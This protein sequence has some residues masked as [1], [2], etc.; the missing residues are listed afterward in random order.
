M[1]AFGRNRRPSPMFAL[2]GR[3]GAAARS[4]RWVLG[5]VMIAALAA[6]NESSVND[7][8]SSTSGTAIAAKPV[9]SLEPNPSSIVKGSLTALSWSASG[10]Q[11]CAASGG[12]SGTRPTTGTLSIDRLNATTTYTLTCTGPGGSTTQTTKVAVT[13]SPPSVTLTAGPTTLAG[14]GSATLSWNSTDATVCTASRGWSGPVATSGSWSTGALSNTTDY[15]LTCTGVGGSATQSAT[16][17]VSELAS[18]VALTANPSTV[19]SGSATTLTW[20]SSGATTCSA[21]GAWLGVKAAHGSQSTGPLT[22]NAT[23][24]LICTGAMGSATQSATVSVKSPAPTV[25]LGAGPSTLASGTSSTL[26]WSAANATSCEASGAW[27]GLRSVSGVQSTGVLTAGATY[28]LTCAGPGGSAAQ[29]ATVSVKPQAPSVSLSVGPSAIA[30]GGSA[31][32]NWSA[33]NA[34]TCSASGGWS[35]S[36]AITGSQSTGTLK[37][38]AIFTLTCSG[39]GGSA[40]QSATLTVSLHPTVTVGFSASPSTIAS[41]RGSTLTWS[42]NG[43]TSCTA[44]GAWSGSKALSG[45]QSTG[46]LTANATYILTCSGNGGSATQSVT[47]SVTAPA[48]TISLGAS[49]STVASGSGST[50]TWS[51]TNATSCTGSGAWSG[52]KAISGSQSTG[53]LTADESYTLTCSGA[54]GSAAQS[55]TVSVTKPAPTVS[56]AASP[57]TIA[58]GSSSTLTWSTANATACTASGT[59]SGSKAVN[60]SASTGALAADETYTLTC[61]GSGGSAV[62][63]ATVSVTTPAPAVSFS[64]SPSTVAKGAISTLTWSSTHATSCT[65]SGGWSGP[66][67]TSGSQAT[68]AIA[69]T[70]TYTLSCSGPG[71]SATQSATVTTAGG[72]GT[73]TLS[74]VAPTTNTNGTPVTPLSGYHI[75]YGTSASALTQSV[76]IS[77]T[78]TASYEITGLTSGTWYFAVAA[79]A[80][81]GTESALS[82][83]GSK[84]I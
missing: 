47:V 73:A 8:S 49:P 66:E 69:V 60:G 13:S 29:S 78:A 2:H 10:A 18:L 1:F 75:Y 4:V 51:S 56:L 80:S 20:S 35:G 45:S 57:S 64:A 37:A 7:N 31:T 58:G 59:W 27:A 23:Y 68:G 41:G 62:Q 9:I 39:T 21:S 14:G 33:T 25:S 26:R 71:G 83:L 50:L 55:A 77:G 84:T 54:G 70:T 46:T 43:A 34:T 24:T 82:D 65:A 5:F 16:V 53:A 12:W 72:T 52:S 11:T 76:E 30:G 74:W 6:C 48:P 81:D 15:E 19:N 38:T 36:K 79:D 63:S 22:A 40:A 61:S 44:T 17:T 3:Y 32:L 67:A 42:S 28:T